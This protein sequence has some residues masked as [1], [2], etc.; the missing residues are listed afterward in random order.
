MVRAGLSKGLRGAIAQGH[1]MIWGTTWANCRSNIFR[2]ISFSY[3]AL[4]SM[5]QSYLTS[6]S[7]NF[8]GFLTYLHTGGK[9]CLFPAPL[10]QTVFCPSGSV[11]V[12][13]FCPP[14]P[15]LVGRHDD[16]NL[17]KEIRKKKKI[18]IM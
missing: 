14:P 18:K 12:E 17:I 3:V 5:A 10:F 11:L 2:I 15:Y 13:Y 6:T 4:T 9:G 1:H 8:L 7:T 16:E